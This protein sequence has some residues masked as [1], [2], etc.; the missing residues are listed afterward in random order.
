MKKLSIGTIAFSKTQTAWIKGIGMLLILFHNFFHWVDPST[1]ENEFDFWSERIFRLFSLLAD[2]PMESINLIFSY[3]GHY[4]VQLFIFIS[5]YGL[6]KSFSAS[7]KWTDFFKSRVIKIYPSFLT[8]IFILFLTVIFLSQSFPD[9]K[10]LN[11]IGYKL[12]F[13]HTLIPGEALSI[14]GPWWFYALIF[15]LY[16]IF[17]FLYRFIDKY[18]LKAF[19]TICFISYAVIFIFYKPFLNNSL[20]LMANFPGH[21]PEFCLG[22]FIALKPN[23]KIHPIWFAGAITVF[24]L[25]NFLFCFYPLTFLSVTFLMVVSIRYILI[26]INEKVIE[27]NYLVFIGNISMFIFAVHGFLRT[28]LVNLAN[29]FHN[30]YITITL[31][32][33]YFLI[34]IGI[35]LSSIKLYN[36][37]ALWLSAISV[38]SFI[39][40]VK[41][42]LVMFFRKQNMNE[43]IQ[44]YFHV[45]IY[46]LISIF[47]IK[48]IFI[49]WYHIDISFAI[50]DIKILLTGL[51]R[52][53]FLFSIFYAALWPLVFLMKVF[54]KNPVHQILVISGYLYL[55]LLCSLTAYFITAQVPLDR[56][57]FMYT[58]NELVDIVVT[59]GSFN[60]W[61]LIL[62]SLSLTLFTVLI[63]IKPRFHSIFKFFALQLLLYSVFFSWG[64]INYKNEQ[65]DNEKKYYLGSSLTRHFFESILQTQSIDIEKDVFKSA[66]LYQSLFPEFKY[67]SRKYPFYHKTDYEDKLG[68]FFLT[69]SSKRPNFVFIIVESLSTSYATCRSNGISVTP[70]LDSLSAH[71]LLWPNCL[72][73]SERT[74]GVLSSVFASSPYGKGFSDMK[75]QMPDHLSL[76]KYLTLHGYHSRFFY[77][78]DPNF[79]GMLQFMELNNTGFPLVN[80]DSTVA[81]ISEDPKNNWGWDD[82]TLFKNAYKLIDT[83]PCDQP[84]IDIF[85]TLSSHDPFMF[86]LKEEYQKKLLKYLRSKHYTEG[87][88]SVIK[89]SIKA[90]SSVFFADDALRL[91]FE[92]YKTRPDFN[93]TIFV[94]TGDHHLQVVPMNSE[95]EKYHVPLLIYSPMLKEPHIFKPVVSH[96]DITPSFIALVKSNYY[97]DI[98]FAGHWLGTGLDTVSEFRALKRM[99][100]IRNNRE[101]VDYLFDSY[102][103]NNGKLFIVKDSLNTIPEENKVMNDSIE[104]ILHCFKILNSYVVDKNMLIPSSEKTDAIS[105]KIF[106]MVNY[107]FEDNDIADIFDKELLTGKNPIMGNKSMMLLKNT[108]YGS[109]APNFYLSS[110]YDRIEVENQFCLRY[111]DENAD[112]Y[113]FLLVQFWKNDKIVLSS[114]HRLDPVDLIKKEGYYIFSINDVFRP[115]TDL[116][117]AVMKVFIH[118]P[119]KAEM[120]YDNIKSSL[121]IY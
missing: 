74:F 91:L 75:D 82:K 111:F 77:G 116:S 55:V 31:S 103:L 1:G 92:N 86:P 94:I 12:L 10:W 73:A 23:L 7:T 9:A 110:D 64:Y 89:N 2:N 90:Y 39:I 100:F 54:F 93:N 26:N 108:L 53:I 84:R 62:F 101:I 107:D 27:K 120:M 56:V 97:P 105:K 69:D 46:L 121:K 117:N 96:L 30:P 85:L 87:D 95:I 119:D 81:C 80:T 18:G 19:W 16:L 79:N 42:R 4:G 32:L 34:V 36:Q 58:Y 68:K 50:S 66:T 115:D 118:N 109:F 88:L 106:R 11:Q 25:G 35:T 48:I 29:H 65:F 17:P 60:I 37:A 14:N 99:A 20:F 47:T 72:A 43:F 63:I 70:F 15:Q 76:L 21:L 41:N 28:P 104:N 5:G 83:L 102:Y 59:S 61:N 52:E 98:S 40:R 8:A 51:L 44:N 22:I 49:A 78:G 33:V 3:F 57:V 6:A 13:L 24:I 114:Q 45:Y 38:N 71:S 112:N 67:Q 113:P